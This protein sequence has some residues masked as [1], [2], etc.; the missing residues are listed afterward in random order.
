MP[1]RFEL[2]YTDKNNEKKRPIM[3][4]RAV[5]GSLERFIGILL[6]HTNGRLP[7]WLAPIQVRILNFTDRNKK[8]SE[9]ILKQLEEEIPTLR[10]DSDFASET[11][12]SKVKDAEIMK[13]PYILVVGDKEEKSGKI[14]VRKNGKIESIKVDKFVKMIKE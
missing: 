13:I 12:P 4:H 1:E 8:Y 9:K 3:V 7:L 11:I 6:E 2:E 5:Y 10:V 14:A